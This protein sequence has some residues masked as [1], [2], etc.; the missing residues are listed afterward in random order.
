M[1]KSP[2]LLPIAIGRKIPLQDCAV[3]AANGE[4]EA[5]ILRKLDAGHMRRV[6]SVLLELGALL[7]A[8]V[9]EELDLP[10]QT[11]TPKARSQVQLSQKKGH[12]RSH[13]ARIV[14]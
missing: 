14:C 2:V 11:Q 9:A 7:D 13:L 5:V 12:W 4:D 1:Y 6:P 10:F 8:R 3:V